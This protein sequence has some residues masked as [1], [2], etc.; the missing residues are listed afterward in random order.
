MVIAAAACEMHPT[1]VLRTA[2]TRGVREALERAT[3]EARDAGVTRVPALRVGDTVHLGDEGLDDWFA[4]RLEAQGIRARRP[5]IPAAR[6]GAVVALA[7][8][9]FIFGW[10]L[11]GASGSYG[12]LAA[13]RAPRGGRYLVGGEPTGNRFVAGSKGCLRIRAE[14]RGTSGHSSAPG[15]GR[16]AVL[17]LL[18][19]LAELRTAHRFDPVAHR[20]NHFKIVELRLVRF[21][22]GGSYP[23]FPDN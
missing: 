21:S 4:R 1:A 13:N 2:R 17:P 12:A 10:V 20:N 18:D 8:A 6:I 7:A 14:A 11:Q 9:I 15:S 5:R 3:A 22:I 19:F 16:S 23:E